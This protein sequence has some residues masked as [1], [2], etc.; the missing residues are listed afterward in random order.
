MNN[1]IESSEKPSPRNT[2][3]IK[4]ISLW[5][6]L[7]IAVVVFV[8]V[9]N[10]QQENEP[11]TLTAKFLLSGELGIKF[12]F[13]AS[14]TSGESISVTTELGK[15]K[16][17]ILTTDKLEISSCKL[18]RLAGTGRLILEIFSDTNLVTTVELPADKR[19][20]ELKK[21]GWSHKEL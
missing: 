20:V 14:A 18:E 21:D 19:I 8:V 16:Q 17:N 15:A 3:R 11:K 5:I 13:N 2:G 6:A 4:R 9:K 7:I 10:K 1:S 12:T